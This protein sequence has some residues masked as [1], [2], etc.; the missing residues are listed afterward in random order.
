MGCNDIVEL[1]R[2]FD[3]TSHVGLGW[4][5]WGV[6]TSLSL[7]ARLMLRHMWGWGGWGGVGCNDIVELARTFDATSHVGLGWVGWGVMTSLNLHARLM[8]RHMWGWG[9]WGGV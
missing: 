1:A 2:T 9:G 8:L 4:V 7:H 6:M 3:A 5:G